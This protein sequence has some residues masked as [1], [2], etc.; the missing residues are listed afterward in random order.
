MGALIA[1]GRAVLDLPATLDGAGRGGWLPPYNAGEWWNV[2]GSVW[3]LVRSSVAAAVRADDKTVEQWKKHGKVH[4]LEEVD[5]FAPVPRPGKLICI[6][7]NY[8]DHAAES[9]M[10][11]PAN[12]VMFSKFSTSIVGPDAAV[13]LP[14]GS[15]KS[16]YEAELAFVIGRTAKR[17]TRADAMNHVVGYCCFND[18]SERGFQF[19]DGQWQRGKSCDT[20]APMGPYVVTADE[21]ANPHDLAI[22]LRLNGQTMQNARTSDLI[23]DIPHL[24]E[25]ISQSIT[26]EP[27]DVIATGTPPGVG[28]A[29]TPP[30][31][32]KAGDRM[33]VE[34]EGLGVLAS[35]VVAAR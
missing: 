11:V 1:Q 26:L 25:F 18:V 17:V 6:G 9:K 20:F 7:L 22:K 19:S 35:S 32:L 16:D 10:A 27:G 34:I 33:E 28:F 29:R 4:A 15:E 30:V 24:I 21:V 14:V 23:F 31:F 13:V 8:R 5:L 12:P 2:D 3:S